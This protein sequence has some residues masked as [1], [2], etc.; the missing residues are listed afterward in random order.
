MVYFGIELN[1]CGKATPKVVTWSSDKT[2][3][4]FTLKHEDCT[5]KKRSVGEK[6]KDEWRRD[7]IRGVGNADVEIGEFGFAKI[8]EHDVELSLFRP[9]GLQIKQEKIVQMLVC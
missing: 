6:F 9:E 8:S 1:V 5:S 4:K 2:E 3:C 7:L